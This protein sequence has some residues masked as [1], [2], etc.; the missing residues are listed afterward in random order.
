MFC[1]HSYFK[2]LL[3]AAFV[4]MIA[5]AEAQTGWHDATGANSYNLKAVD[6]LPSLAGA[7]VGDESTVLHTTDG[8]R[9]WTEQ[10]ALPGVDFRAVS[11][12]NDQVGL[13]GGTLG[14]IL[15]TPNGG[16]AWDSIQSGWLTN[17]YGAH[18]L[19][20]QRGVVAGQNTIF[21][22]LVTFTTNHWQTFDSRVFYIDHDATGYEGELHDIKMLDS[23]TWVA[24]ASVWDG[25]GAIVRTVNSGTTWTTAAWTTAPINAVDFPTPQTGYA[26]GNSGLVYK[27]INGGQTWVQLNFTLRVH[28]YDVKFVNPDT[29]WVV[30]E[31]AAI[32]RTDDGGQNWHSQYTG[33]GS[34]RSI[35]FADARHGAAVGDN[36]LALYTNTGGETNN[37]PGT[38]RRLLPVDSAAD[39][40]EEVPTVRFVWSRSHDEDGD[41]VMYH[42]NIHSDFAHFNMDTITPDTMRRQR[43]PLIVL[44]EL[45]PFYW[46]VWALDGVDST[47]ASNGT[48]VILITE[49]NAVEHSFLAR[50][51]ALAV[52]PNPFNPTATISFSLPAAQLVQ[53]RVMDVLGRTV[54]EALLGKMTAGAHDIRFDGSALPSGLYFATLETPQARLSQKMLL[55]K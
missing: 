36:G 24:A 26:A 32:Y 9:T 18:M 29:G 1:I 19:N 11:L 55:V 2:I 5:T 48:G 47:Q 42:F 43:I 39:P 35:D 22:P 25:H 52:Y 31:N 28:W 16:G 14:T 53:I 23:V 41:P 45:V 46:S 15:Y 33:T 10:T 34:L 12:A 51:F 21:Q 50:E 40:F 49:E 30:G 3:A 7:A 37:A 44:D 20:A 8:G 17:Y 4:I 38:F 6:L 13:I 27:S 54:Q